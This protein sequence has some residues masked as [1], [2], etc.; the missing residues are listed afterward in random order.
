MRLSKPAVRS[1]DEI[2][3]VFIHRVATAMQL[4][5]E[6][7]GTYKLSEEMSAKLRRRLIKT[8]EQENLH[9]QEESS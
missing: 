3:R 6:A 2:T 4:N 1:M 5:F 7:N 9:G 8:I